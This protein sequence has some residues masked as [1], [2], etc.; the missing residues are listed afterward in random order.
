MTQAIPNPID[1]LAGALECSRNSLDAESAMYRTYG[2]DSFGHLRVILDLEKAYGI[3]A[4]EEN[5][6]KFKTL[7]AI[8]ELY[9]CLMREGEGS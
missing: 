1:L 4:S 5:F 3:E 9:E 8:Q 2:W 7:N 6:Q